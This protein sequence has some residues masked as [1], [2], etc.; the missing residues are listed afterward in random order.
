MTYLRLRK[1]PL[2]EPQMA[3]PQMA[4]GMMASGAQMKGSAH[5]PNATATRAMNAGRTMHH[6]HGLSMAG[7]VAQGVGC[8]RG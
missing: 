7:T 5:M 3:N 1:L 2:K 6:G 8:D 4:S